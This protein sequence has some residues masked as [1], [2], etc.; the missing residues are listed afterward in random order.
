MYRKVVPMSGTDRQTDSP[1]TLSLLFKGDNELYA[2]VRYVRL[3]W[4]CAHAYV[5]SQLFMYMHACVCVYTHI[6][7]CVCA[8]VHIYAHVYVYLRICTCMYTCVR[9]RKCMYDG[10][11][12]YSRPHIDAKCIRCQ[13]S[14]H[15]CI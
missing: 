6:S 9:V 1:K 8:R 12:T 13:D 11:L 15:F 7:V 14:Q 5:Y 4:V 2:C 10:Q 3:L